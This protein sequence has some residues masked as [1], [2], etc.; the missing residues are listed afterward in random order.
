MQKKYLADDCS[1][2]D[3]KTYQIEVNN[4]LKLN[5][6]EWADKEPISLEDFGGTVGILSGNQCALDK[7]ILNTQQEFIKAIQEAFIE[8]EIPMI[9]GSDPLI[10]EAALEVTK[11]RSSDCSEFTLSD[12]ELGKI[13]LKYF[14]QQ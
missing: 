1:Y 5:K 11:Y 7:G 3:E 4:M 14:K 12:L 2:I 6:I 13:I 8:Y 10:I 9:Y